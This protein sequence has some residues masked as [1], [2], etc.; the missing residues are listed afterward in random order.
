[1]ALDPNF[2]TTPKYATALLTTATTVMDGTGVTPL[3]IAGT[4]G[5]LVTDLKVIPR[6]TVS[7]T[8]V[9]LYISQDDGTSWAIIDSVN[10]AAYTLSQTAS[11]TMVRF[12]DK[13]NPDGA[14]R[15][16]ADCHLGVSMGVAQSAGLT[17]NAEYL[18]Y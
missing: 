15:I 13:S 16:P 3:L 14:L 17:I 9:R 2:P 6:G 8:V 5:S 12:V 11:P 10:L 18:D 4:E 1:M 7:A